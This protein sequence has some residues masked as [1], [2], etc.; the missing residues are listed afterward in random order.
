MPA[1]PAQEAA[2]TKRL[3]ELEDVLQ[4][5]GQRLQ[6]ISD[7]QEALWQESDIMLEEVGMSLAETASVVTIF[8]GFGEGQ[9]QTIVSTGQ[10]WPQQDSSGL[11]RHRSQT[12]SYRR[13]G[14]Q[15]RS[16]AS[17]PRPSQRSRGGHRAG[18]NKRRREEV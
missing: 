16:E 10:T 11:A 18:G 3:T 14:D 6:R 1:N 2:Y 5:A 9:P 4:R 17:A 8:D 13:T 7:R 15:E 12:P